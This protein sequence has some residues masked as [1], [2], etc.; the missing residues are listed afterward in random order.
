MNAF[1]I[2][3]AVG[4]LAIY[5][6]VLGFLHLRRRPKVVSG[7]RDLA[8]LGLAMI[9]LFLIGPAQLF[10]PQAAF[11]LFG[12]S[13]WIAL[14]LLYLFILVFSILNARPSLVVFGLDSDSLSS[15]VD[16]VLLQ[17]DPGTKWL[18][19]TF[20]AP[21][22]GIQGIVESA[23]VGRVSHAIATKRE[24]NLIGWLILGRA[25]SANLKALEVERSSSGYRWLVLGLALLSLI[26]FTLINQPT[27]VTQ[28]IRE[29]LRN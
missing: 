2:I 26:G 29:I 7:G 27:A 3:L 20:I 17:L 9:G 1:S 15:Q 14:V 6:I 13:V 8:C 12:S 11:N 4:P 18:N 25:L 28:G 19:H 10:F 5:C 21:A 16:H 22:L 23:G 24:Q